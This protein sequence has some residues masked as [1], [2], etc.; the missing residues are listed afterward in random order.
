MIMGIATVELI[1]PVAMNWD[2][3]AK[4]NADIDIAAADER[5]LLTA[6]APKIIPNGT[7]PTTRGIVARTPAQ[8]SLHREARASNGSFKLIIKNLC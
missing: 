3:P 2:D 4:T 6:K 7:A 1:N 8:N 5:P